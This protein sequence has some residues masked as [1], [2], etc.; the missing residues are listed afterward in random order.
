MNY[1]AIYGMLY[2]SDGLYVDDNGNKGTNHKY[3]RE[4]H[5]KLAK[6]QRRLSRMKG[7][8][9][10]EEKSANYLKQLKK[11]NRIHKHIANQRLDNLH[12]RSTE[13]AN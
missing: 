1:I 13:I 9:K 12:K 3:Y 10:K 8:K 4:S 5:R 2:A 11:V 6:S 7:S